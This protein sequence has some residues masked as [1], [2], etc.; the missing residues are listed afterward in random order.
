MPS[1]ISSIQAALDP[2][3]LRKRET[4]AIISSQIGTREFIVK[5]AGRSIVVKSAVSDTLKIGDSV[6]LANTAHGKFIVGVETIK[7][8]AIITV[9]ING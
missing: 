7:N 4:T 1:I 2:K 6:V 5:E 8:R 9:I 3:K